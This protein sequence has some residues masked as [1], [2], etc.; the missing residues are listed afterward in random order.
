ML[1]V[2]EGAV[3]GDVEHAAAALDELGLRAELCGNLGRQTGGL[4]QVASA[5]AV[6]DGDAHDPAPVAMVI[7]LQSRTTAQLPRPNYLK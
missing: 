3:G 1:G 7:I 6:I 5:D 2:D 4:G